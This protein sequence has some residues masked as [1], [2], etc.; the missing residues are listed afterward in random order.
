MLEKQFNVTLESEQRLMLSILKSSRSIKVDLIFA[1]KKIPKGPK[2]DATIPKIPFLVGISTLF[3][4]RFK[5]KKYF[6]YIPFHF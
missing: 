5:D 4:Q 3:Q 1:P 6:A 2:I